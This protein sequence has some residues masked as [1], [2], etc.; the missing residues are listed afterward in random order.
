MT[1]NGPHPIYLSPFS[2]KKKGP[3][4]SGERRRPPPRFFFFFNS[5]FLQGSSGF[6]DLPSYECFPGYPLPLQCV[7][8]ETDAAKA[9]ETKGG[10]GYGG[11][12]LLVNEPRPC[13]SWWAAALLPSSS[14]FLVHLAI[15]M[16]PSFIPPSPPLS[17]HPSPSSS[18]QCFSRGPGI[19]G[20]T[21]VGIETTFHVIAHDR[22]GNRK[23]NGGKPALVGISGADGAL[24]AA[25]AAAAGGGGGGGGWLL[26]Y[27]VMTT[28]LLLLSLPLLKASL[29]PLSS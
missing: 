9:R 4:F 17:L 6:R 7:P 29:P 24:A 15:S 18:L 19:R 13:P 10:G 5:P 21:K 14:A 16:T 23:L 8:G 25:A 11:C 27:L 12:E 26:A 2:Q 20:K 28:C 22:L 3:K 1:R